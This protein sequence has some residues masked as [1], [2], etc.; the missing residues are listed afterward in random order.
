M[1]RVLE[2]DLSAVLHNASRIVAIESA[3]RTVIHVVVR[4]G[5]LRMIPEV[6][7]LNPNLSSDVLCNVR[8]LNRDKSV[9]QIAGPLNVFLPRL[10]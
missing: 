3:E 1:L 7:E 9:F 5:L 6:E 8:I 4:N 2:N 10:P